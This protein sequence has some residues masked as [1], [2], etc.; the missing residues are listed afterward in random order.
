VATYDAPYRE[1]YTLPS[2][3]F[4][5]TTATQSW[6]GPAG[7]T[8]LV[9]DIEVYATAD[10]VGTTTVPEVDV[11]TASGAVEYAR[12]RLGTSATAGL[13]AASTPI[14]ART[15]VQGNPTPPVNTTFTGYVALETARI[16]ADT[17][18]VITAKAGTGGTPAGTG[19]VRVTI[20]WF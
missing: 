6:I 16:P 8:G 10:F 14:R 7:R 9:R 19:I 5:A 2:S 12:F 4:G 1:H 11:G 17:A 20:D 18:F 3:A 15:Q 13:A